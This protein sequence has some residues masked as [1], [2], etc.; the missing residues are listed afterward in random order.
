MK[1]EDLADFALEMPMCIVVIQMPDGTQ[2]TTTGC[3][4]G[5][6]KR[7]RFLLFMLAR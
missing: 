7:A 5:S 4:Y 1:T 3:T 6:D 2:I